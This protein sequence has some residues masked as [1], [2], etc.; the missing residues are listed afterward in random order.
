M[1]SF[2]PAQ[3]HIQHFGLWRAALA[4][5]F[6]A[7]LGGLLAWRL[8][9]APQSDALPWLALTA[10]TIGL[11]V[12]M[13]QML[14]PAPVRLR[15]DAQCWHLGRADSVGDDAVQVD[16]SVAVDLG[17]WMLLRLLPAHGA[18]ARRTI[19]LPVQRR[20]MQTQW[21]ALRCAVHSPRPA[22]GQDAAADA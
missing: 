14:N 16:L 5:L 9:Q 8:A 21:H 17:N 2:A 20:G 18:S 6:L 7:A 11:A 4:A 3:F 12:S 15:W 1:R 10:A 13:R 19:W 22:T